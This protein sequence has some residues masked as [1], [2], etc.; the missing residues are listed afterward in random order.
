MRQLP[1]SS[2]CVPG[3]A[4][5]GTKLWAPSRVPWVPPIGQKL[6]PGSG[7]HFS[8]SQNAGD[9]AQILATQLGPND[10]ER[11]HQPLFPRGWAQVP[12]L[13]ITLLTAHGT[14]FTSCGLLST[15]LGNIASSGPVNNSTG[16]QT[17]ILEPTVSHTSSG[18]TLAPIPYFT[19][20]DWSGNA[21]YTLATRTRAVCVFLKPELTCS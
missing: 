4:F 7:R 1:V 10:P 15:H 12:I 21:D 5:C 8:G 13:I 9:S 2:I 20:R 3:E 17:P 6:F 14:N 16:A 11:I 18:Q 19:M